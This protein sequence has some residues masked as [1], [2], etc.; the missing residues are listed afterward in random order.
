MQAQTGTNIKAYLILGLLKFTVAGELA[1]DHPLNS[2]FIFKH[3]E[4]RLP[5]GV[6]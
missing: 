4:I 6:G 2:K 1:I 3:S 5:K